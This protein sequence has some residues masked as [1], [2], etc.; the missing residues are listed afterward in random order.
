M[1]TF[2]DRIDFLIEQVGKNHLEGTVEINQVYAHY[3]HEHPEFKHPMGG[4]SGFLR[5]PLF[6]GVTGF[7]EHMAE[8]AINPDGS[9]IQTAMAENMESLSKK[10][11]EQSPVEFGDLR[12]SGHPVVKS[13]GAT[14]YDRAPMARRLTEQELKAKSKLRHLLPA[15]VRKG[16][17]RRSKG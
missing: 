8:K 14:V 11:Y 4:K 6:D 13:D 12:D 17:A 10:A 15:Q 7:M 16:F 3:Q 5:D 1:G 9:E 2:G